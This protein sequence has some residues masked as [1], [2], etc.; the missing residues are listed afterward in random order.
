M[1]T[2]MMDPK[3]IDNLARR[4]SNAV[5]AGLREAQQDIE[6]NFRTVL[7]NTL[8][9]LDLVT[10]EDAERLK[11]SGLID[12]AR[13]AA[14]EAGACPHTVIREDPTLNIA[15]ADELE[16]ALPGLDLAAAETVAAGLKEALRVGTERGTA[17][18]SAMVTSIVL[19]V[20]ADAVITLIYNV[21]DF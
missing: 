7:Q 8:A 19:V 6:K 5:P 10:R 15:A 2:G 21:L 14:V 13:V 12:P 1:V 17:T 3:V 20:I 9:K 16:A 4:L 18:T 11:R